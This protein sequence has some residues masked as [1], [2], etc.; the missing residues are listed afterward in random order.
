MQDLI[1]TDSMVKFNVIHVHVIKIV[2]A[3]GYLQHWHKV[4]FAKLKSKLKLVV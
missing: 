3:G 1:G 4:G 2:K